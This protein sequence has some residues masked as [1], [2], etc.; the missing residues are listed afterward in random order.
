MPVLL[1]CIDVPACQQEGPVDDL[2]MLTV[3]V[4]LLSV[5]S[6][7]MIVNVFILFISTLSWYSLMG[8][9]AKQLLTGQ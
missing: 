2:C 8:M 4:S 5:L 1:V 9:L 7:A 6:S 3:N